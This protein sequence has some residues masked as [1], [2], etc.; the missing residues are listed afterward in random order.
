[1][2]GRNLLEHPR[3]RD[4]EILTPSHSDLN[5]LDKNQVIE[6]FTLHPVDLVVHAA[7]VVGGIL[8]NMSA[9]V[10]F[11]VENTDISRNLI[12]GAFE[13]GVPQFINLGSSCMY[14][15]NRSCALVEDMLL[16][17][18]LEPTNE[19]YALSKIFA[20]RLCQYLNREHPGL[21][22]KTLIPCNLFGRWDHF[23]SGTQSHMIA[24][25]FDKIYAARQGNIGEVTIWGAGT[26]RREFM[27]AAE[28]ADAIFWAIDRIEHL[29]DLLNVGAGIDYTV[30]EYY[31]EI[32]EAFGYEGKLVYDTSKPEGM[33]RKLL[34]VSKL[35][36]LGWKC[37]TSLKEG[38]RKTYEFYCK[39]GRSAASLLSR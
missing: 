27:Y 34:E 5:L 17:G 36:V 19:G 4:V 1:M 23:H 18:P 12:I 29:P 14:P 37:S 39:Q 24:A 11:M 6:F 20:V 35:A 33:N 7:G 26:A 22:Y 21:H 15:R 28:V 16:D 9:P 8:A 3:A 13:A 38:I 10:R 32:A 25:A 31:K 2:V 30:T